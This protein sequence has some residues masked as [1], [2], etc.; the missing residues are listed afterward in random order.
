[1]AEVTVVS[2]WKT[3]AGLMEA[4]SAGVENHCLFR[5]FTMAFTSHTMH[6]SAEERE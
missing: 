6:V 1:M 4:R 2:H 5:R 3:S